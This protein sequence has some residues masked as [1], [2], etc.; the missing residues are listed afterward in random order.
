MLPFLNQLYWELYRLWT[1]P[2]TYIGFGA[3]L[4]FDIAAALLLHVP[5]V[6]T[7]MAHDVW[8]SATLLGGSAFAGPSIAVHTLGESITIMGTLGFALVGSDLVAKEAEDGTLRM[9]LCRP[10]L[11]ISL[12]LQKLGVAL[13]Y[14]VALT[15]FAS[16]TSL[17]VGLLFEGPGPLV[18]I[19]SHEGIV[20]TFDFAAGMHRYYLATLLLMVSSASGVLVPFALGCLKMKPSLAAVIALTFFFADDI[21]RT[22]PSLS[23]ATP[24]SYTTRLITWRQAF[25]NEISWLKV[26]RNYKQLLW[27]DAALIAGAWLAFSCRSARPR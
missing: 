4:V 26:R 7:A 9:I 22:Q 15:L 11:R 3:C 18:L 1:R 27:I 5:G 8:R 19:A 21:V 23:Q 20:G 17:V 10:V 16:A 14:A 6:R 13:A 24:H 12:F 25:N 2:R